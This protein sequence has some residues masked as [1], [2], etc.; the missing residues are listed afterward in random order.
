LPWG[1]GAEGQR[2]EPGSDESI[3]VCRVPSK[4]QNRILLTG[5]TGYVGGR[6]MR[7]LEADGYS[8]RC[9]ARN[10]AQLKGRV[11]ETTEIVA[12]DCL[13]PPSLGVALAGIH[14]AY[15]LV[16]SMGNADSFEEQD[17]TAAVN[18][19][20]AA[21]AAGVKR[22][23]YLGG[24]G[25]GPLS[26]HLKSR[27]E[28]GAILRRSKVPVIEFRASIV[29]GSGSLSFEIIRA[30]VERL[31][32]MVCPR[33]VAMAA[34]PIAV[35]DLIEYLV[36][37]MD[38]ADPGSRIIEIGGPDR[39]SYRDIMN[40]YARQR[41]LKRLMISIPVLTPR[42]SS[43][44]LGLVTPVYARIGR[45]LIDSIRNETVVTDRSALTLFSFKPMGLAE[46]M[47]RAIA[48]EDREFALTRWSDAL[49]SSG[50]EPSWGGVRFGNR[51]VDSRTA[52]VEAPPEAAF[53]LIRRIGGTN[54]WYFGNWL[55]ALRGFLDLLLGGVGLRRGRRDPNSMRVGDT[56]DFWRVEAFENNRRL[57]LS[58]EMKLPGRA[59][60]EFEVEA[61]GSA[62]LVRQTAIF[63]P[64]GLA[65]L[66]YWYI[67]YPLHCLMF[68][69]MLRRIAAVAKAESLD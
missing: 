1:A 40:E 49:S 48:N 61:K 53:R 5:A 36:R 39:V 25:R 56:L 64:L 23:I 65:G 51:I 11:A 30:L 41:G 19:A 12:G 57:R 4:R 27:Q 17:R 50:L 62:S 29:I 45:K 24:L 59:W 60:L 20:E 43:L 22:I 35:E 67:L 21:E 44:W 55:W 33:W 9:L 32:V 2:T 38:L 15:Y 69:Q 34:Q 10:P 66:A 31:P 46:M 14:T 8:L 52:T 63:D 3:E 58:A 54:G 42:L 18:F 37:A 28:V 47:R 16:H 68:A 26:P 13:D 7:V 6:L